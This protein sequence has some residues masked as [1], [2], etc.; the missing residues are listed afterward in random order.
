MTH[1]ELISEYP[2][3]I[4][5]AIQ[6]ATRYVEPLDGAEALRRNEQVQDAVVRNIEIIGE[7]AS[8]M[9]NADSG[10]VAGHPDV[11]WAEMRGMRNKMIH[12]YFDVDWQ[13]VW[14]TVK[15]DF[16]RLQQQIDALLIARRQM[17]GDGGS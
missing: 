10:F 13:V 11:P 15:E 9:Q 17:A 5:E 8:R 14:A 6:R 7:A 1:P 4:V 3:H 16:P 12:E 2:E